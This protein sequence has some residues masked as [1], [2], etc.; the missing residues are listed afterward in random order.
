M[1]AQ[2][3]G[4]VARDYSEFWMGHTGDVTARHYTT[5]RAR[6]PDSLVASMRKA[7]ARCEQ[8][9]STAPSRAATSLREERRVLLSAWYSDKEVE[10]VDLDD[11]AAVIEAV[12]KGVARGAVHAGPTQQVVEDADLPRL[13]SDGW[14]FVSTVNGT[15]AVVERAA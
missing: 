15:K 1:E 13:L 5:G 14:R 11:V 9:L 4:R 6:L 3:A 12:R 8:F 2:N 10:G 7:Y